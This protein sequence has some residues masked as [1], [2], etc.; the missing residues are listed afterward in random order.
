MGILSETND[1]TALGFLFL[2]GGIIGI[3]LGG[4]ICGLFPIIGLIMIV[5]GITYNPLKKKNDE[6]K[7]FCPK[8]GR[9]IPFDAN[10]CPY[11]KHDFE[12]L[13]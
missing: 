2:I 11:C 13:K 4:P 12:E 7:R 8:C 1:V 3:I 9:E 6:S 10:V 5:V